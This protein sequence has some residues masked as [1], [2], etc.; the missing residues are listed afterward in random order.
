MKS[1]P[2]VY[3][4]VLLIVILETSAMS[5][6]KR[7][8]DYQP[9]FALGVLF[10][11]GVGYLLCQ[12]FHNTGMAMTNA[13]WSGISVMSTT[14]VGI[15][16]FKEMLHTHDYFAIALIVSGVMILKVTD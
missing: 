13:L 1:I 16:L 4:Y 11:A 2:R 14:I 9:F 6:F 12:T 5:C 8:L 15:L 10:Y 7:S 3:W